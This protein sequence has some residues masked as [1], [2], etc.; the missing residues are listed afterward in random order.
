MA[1]IRIIFGFET[2]STVQ[3]DL[4]VSKIGAGAGVGAGGVGN[5]I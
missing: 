4:Q 1:V 5:D 3:V 2:L